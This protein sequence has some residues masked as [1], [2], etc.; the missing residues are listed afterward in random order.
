MKKWFENLKIA[1]K[2]S[3]GFLFVTILGLII[4]IVGMANMKSM[5]EN[6]QKTYDNCTLGIVYSAEAENRFN[7]AR[8]S[9]RNLYIFY[10]TDKEKYCDDTSTQL[11]AIQTQF[12]NYSKTLIDNQ[13]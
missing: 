10:D 12:D 1:K 6:S 8:A 2:L 3:V 9:I 7:C 5:I 13:D 4:G 11:N